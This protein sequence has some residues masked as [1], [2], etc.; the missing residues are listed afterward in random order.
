MKP[1]IAALAAALSVLAPASASDSEPAWFTYTSTDRMRGEQV[2]A[3]ARTE[4]YFEL[5]APYDGVQQTAELKLR[6]GRRGQGD[7]IFSIQRGI[8]V[9]GPGHCPVTVRW[10]DGPPLSFR[11]SPPS[12]G[13][14]ETIF[15][16]GFGQFVKRLGT[17][18]RLL[19]EV[20]IYQH[21]SRVFEFGT[22]GFDPSAF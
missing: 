6:K 16:P 3:S 13:S 9:C 4:E 18:Q 19:I 7:V 15:I 10:D 8:L 17:A 11:G 5:R 22:S 14:T 12:D 20:D 1:L 21:G 2:I